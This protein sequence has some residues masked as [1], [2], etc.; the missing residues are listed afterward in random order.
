MKP[1]ELKVIS[2]KCRFKCPPFSFNLQK[3]NSPDPEIY[4]NKRGSNFISI[5][6]PL[7]SYVVFASGECNL[8]KVQSIAEA[9]RGK[10]YFLNFFKCSAKRDIIIDNI[11]L[12]TKLPSGPIRQFSLFL[13]A[14]RE[15]LGIEALT[16]NPRRFSGANL[17]MHFGSC[18]VFSSGSCNF[19]GIK[20]FKDFSSVRE[21]LLKVEEIRNRRGF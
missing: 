20:S 19:L 21:W 4:V 8:L 14:L 1:V 12:T 6:S 17:R 7:Y 16:F 2:I 10:V 9:H 13:D 18:I 5:K 15:E 11:A 3:W